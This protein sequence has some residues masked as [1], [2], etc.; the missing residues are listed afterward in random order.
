MLCTWTMIRC[1]ARKVW[2]TSGIANFTAVGFARLERLRLLEAVAEL[3]AHH[4]AADQLLVAAH[5]ARP[6]GFGFGSG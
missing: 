4:V 1:P 6:V 5:A 3:A 2:Q